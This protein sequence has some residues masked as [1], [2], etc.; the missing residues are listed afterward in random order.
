MNDE[1]EENMPSYDHSF[2][3]FFKAMLVKLV[4]HLEDI[5]IEAKEAYFG[6]QICDLSQINE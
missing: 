3:M 1:G 2:P 6:R 4:G 5:I